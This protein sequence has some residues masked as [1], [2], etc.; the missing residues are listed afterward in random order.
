MPLPTEP[1]GSMPRPLELIDLFNRYDQGRISREE[2]SAAEALAV[3]DTIARFEATGSP[4]VTDGEQRKPSFLTY[5][6]AELPNVTRDGL[7]IQFADGHTRSVPRLTAGPFR[8]RRYAVDFLREAQQ[9][10]ERPVKQAVITASALSLMYPQD[11]IPGYPREQFLGELLNEVERDIRLCL[12]AGAHCVQMDFT[13]ARLAIKL[14]PSLHLLQEFIEINNLVLDRFSEED[15]MRIGIH[16]CPGADRDATHSADVSYEYLLPAL[17][18]LKARNF[19][20]QLSSER[21]LSRVLSLIRASVE[22]HQRVFAGVTDPISPKLETPEEVR[23]LIL[24][25]AK[26]IP[27][28]RLGTTDDCG[29]APFADDRSTARDLAFA[30]VQARVEGT[31]LASEKLNV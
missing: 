30:K 2:L 22:P 16:T 17:F 8:F 20:I 9:K 14:D 18:Q 4:V 7:Q 5:P 21:N 12:E 10:T 13:E 6:V 26:Y 15:R 19:Y 28:D 24:E 23:D 1:I 29:F 27:A 31:R 3:A 11:G 25:V